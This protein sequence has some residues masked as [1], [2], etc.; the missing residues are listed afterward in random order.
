MAMNDA[1]KKK[2]LNSF[3]WEHPVIICSADGRAV[4]MNKKAED[5]AFGSVIAEGV[6]NSLSTM[7]RIKYDFTMKSKQPQPFIAAARIVRA[8]SH[9]CIMPCDV[10]DVRIAVAIA[11]KDEIKAEK[12]KRFQARSGKGSLLYIIEKIV[13]SRLPLQERDEPLIDVAKV[14]RRLVSDISALDSFSLSFDVDIAE[15]DVMNM[16][17]DMG[18]YAYINMFVIAASV[19]SEISA[20]GKVHL[21]I[22]PFESFAEVSLVTDTVPGISGFGGEAATGLAESA[23][24]KLKICEYMAKCSGAGLLVKFDSGKVRISLFTGDIDDPVDFKSQIHFAGY[25]DMLR[26]ALNTVDIICKEVSQA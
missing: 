20:T 11:A 22:S 9:L 16:C 6:R 17:S 2:I 24:S 15:A 19:I 12:L 21:S 26:G 14:S 8:Y 13:E 3:Y 23:E 25:E 7:D 1:L 18:M 5:E 10:G 4:F